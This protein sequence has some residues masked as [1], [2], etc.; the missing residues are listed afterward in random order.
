M[1]NHN[2]IKKAIIIFTVINLFVSCRYEKNY[3]RG[4][5]K[6]FSDTQKEQYQKLYQ[7]IKAFDTEE[8]KDLMEKKVNP[9]ICWGD[10][11][12]WATGNPLDVL[13]G[14][15]YDS[16]WRS[17]RSEPVSDPPA[18]MAIFQLL[19]DRRVNLKRRPYIWRRVRM[20]G[21]ETTDYLLAQPERTKG[22]AVPVSAEEAEREAAAVI[23]DANRLLKAMLEAGAP[24]DRRGTFTPYNPSDS[25]WM[26]DEAARDR[27]A[28]GTRPINEAIKKG[29]VWESQVDL[30]LKYT[31]LD[32]DSL[33]AAEESGDSAM[34]EKIT[35]LWAE[36]NGRR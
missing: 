3:N 6:Y 24:A 13:A 14:L 15:Y 11:D 27:F 9:N 25:S 26:D 22:D 4:L 18:D 35:R 29:I 5:K 31:K 28:K 2:R 10:D 19:R 23:N 1:K 12:G 36:Q 30:L 21:K 20:C 8:V 17:L 34:I 7:A 32:E 16:Y 33:A